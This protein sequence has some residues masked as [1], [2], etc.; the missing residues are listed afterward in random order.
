DQAEGD[1]QNGH[2]KQRAQRDPDHESPSTIGPRVRAGKTIRPAVRMMIA[3]SST[4]NVGPSVRKGPA[5]AGTV[6]LAASA[7]PRAS[8]ANI[9]TNRP[10]YSATLPRFAE[11]GNAP[12]P[13]NALPLLFACDV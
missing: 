11:K 3:T 13:A 9:G 8:A 7:P 1:R 10:R 4:V 12:W 2:G 6:F 5:E